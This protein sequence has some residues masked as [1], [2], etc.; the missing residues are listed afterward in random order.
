[1]EALM[2]DGVEPS[3]LY[4]LDLKRAFKKLDEIRPHAV[5]TN[6]N[7]IQNLIAQGEVVTGDLNLAR[8]KALI[9]DGAPLEYTLNQ[10]IVDYV[11]WVVPNG[12]PHPKYAWKLIEASLHPDRQL[13]VLE[14]L[15]YTPTLTGALDNLDV[16]ERQDLAGTPET[17]DKGVVLDP[18]YYREHG[19]KARTAF[20]NWLVKG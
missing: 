13:Q 11:R 2:A 1:E 10:N 5:F 14:L 8:T 19:E 6:L 9:A 15:G 7:T 18:H 20:H 16:E 4:P 3:Q 12:A 17:L